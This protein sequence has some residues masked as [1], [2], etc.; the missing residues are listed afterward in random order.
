MVTKATKMTASQVEENVQ[1]LVKTIW[2]GNGQPSLLEMVR[3]QRRD[4]Q[5]KILPRLTKIEGELQARNDQSSQA[6]IEKWKEKYETL[7]GTDK[8]KKDDRI[9]WTRT[10]AV[11]ILA[12]IVQWGFM[13]LSP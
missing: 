1:L 11:L 7:V 9:Y 10:V 13:W 6:E 2:T 5:E 4:I 12:Q 3:E 8:E